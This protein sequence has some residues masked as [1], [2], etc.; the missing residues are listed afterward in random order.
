MIF[1]RLLIAVMLFAC[2]PGVLPFVGSDGAAFAQDGEPPPGTDGGGGPDRE[3][4][5]GPDTD[6]DLSRELRRDVIEAPIYGVTR[7]ALKATL[8]ARQRFDNNLER[9]SEGDPMAIFHRC[10]A[11]AMAIFANDLE[12]PEVALPES[13]Q[14]APEIIRT[15][16]RRVLNAPDRET[17]R[18]A[19]AEAVVE[20]KKTIALIKAEEPVF[21]TLAD[22]Q[23]RQGNIIAEGLEVAEAKL[24]RAVG[25]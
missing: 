22:M 7:D 2:A 12:K 6:S 5:P 4:R 1:I 8:I 3:P 14:P 10:I 25:L 23:T 15:A 21:A 19:V 17:A 20:V 24:E 13:T 9:C 16:A 11:T 18:A